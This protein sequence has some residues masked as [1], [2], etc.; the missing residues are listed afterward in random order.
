MSSGLKLGIAAML[1]FVGWGIAQHD[2]ANAGFLIPEGT[3][4]GTQTDQF[5]LNAKYISATGAQP[6]AAAPFSLEFTLPSEV[7]FRSLG[8]NDFAVT[9][10]GSYTDNKVTTLFTAAQVLLLSN[11]GFSFN[12]SNFLGG[13]F[14]LGVEFTQPLYQLSYTN[15]GGSGGV[16]TDASFNTGTFLLNP[17]YDN[18]ATFYSDPQITG[19]SGSLEPTSVPEPSSVGL[20]LAPLG[21]LAFLRHRRP[22]AKPAV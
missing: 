1:M 22:T 13:S 5:Q 8:Y 21:L 4:V 11:D 10:S 15:V 16:V 14:S 20:L 2:R 3:A 6:F 7:Q 12:V 17:T 9:V 19:G 18:A